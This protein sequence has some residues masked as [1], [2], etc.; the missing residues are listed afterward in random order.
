MPAIEAVQRLAEDLV[1]HYGEDA[2]TAAADRMH[3]MTSIG[4]TEAAS[5]WAEV[6]E[7]LAYR[8]GRGRLDA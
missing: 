1:A 7:I 2:E 5:L 8:R 4:N 6:S 3:A